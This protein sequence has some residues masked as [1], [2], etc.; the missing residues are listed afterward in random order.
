MAG[1]GTQ[2]L[3]QRARQRPRVRVRQLMRPSAARLRLSSA[4]SPS[5]ACTAGR[6]KPAARGE[7]PRCGIA[8][9]SRVRSLR[10]AM[11][12]ACATFSSVGGR[13]R[14]SSTTPTVTP[15]ASL[16]SAC[17]DP[18]APSRVCG[19]DAEDDGRLAPPG[20]LAPNFGSMSGSAALSSVKEE[21][22]GATWQPEY[23]LSDSLRERQNGIL[24]DAGGIRGC[25]NPNEYGVSGRWRTVRR[26]APTETTTG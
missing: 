25:E 11:S 5:M 17:V 10:P 2:R 14:P 22:V 9:R 6:S 20:F 23:C 24:V 16:S 3:G 4:A 8:A 13:P 18:H 21:V 15:A 19:E 26:P 12:R 1:R 7:W